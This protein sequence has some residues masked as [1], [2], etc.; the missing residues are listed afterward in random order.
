M[1]GGQLGIAQQGREQRFAIAGA[2]VLEREVRFVEAK[3]R[4]IR[5]K[6]SQQRELIAHPLRIAQKAIDFEPGPQNPHGVRAGC[7][8]GGQYLERFLGRISPH[9]DAGLEDH[10]S[11][12]RRVEREDSVGITIGLIETA[13]NDRVKPSHQQRAGI[14]GRKGE[15]G[16]GG[17]ERVLQMPG[18]QPELR[19]S[20]Q[21]FPIG[22]IERHRVTIGVI[23]P[24]ER[25]RRHFDP[26]AQDMKLRLVVT[27][28]DR[29]VDREPR[30]GITP[31]VQQ[32]L[33]ARGILGR[34]RVRALTARRRRHHECQCADPGETDAP[35][36]GLIK[37]QT[38]KF[39]RLMR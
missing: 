3:R 2:P 37:G 30:L 6:A 8:I 24:R 21:R 5:G 17:L 36:E 27:L 28:G 39:L 29:V 20:L 12:V 18:L 14:V 33:R 22:G 11:L 23:G 9:R 15:N 35:S 13:S 34:G 25:A 1:F 32:R 16:V 19:D 10:P 4:V 26:P 38:P 7:A 31:R